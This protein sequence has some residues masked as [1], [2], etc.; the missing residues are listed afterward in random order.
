M[1]YQRNDIARVRIPRCRSLALAAC[2]IT[3]GSAA[4]AQGTKPEPAP[5][6]DT[7]DV[8]VTVQ[9]VVVTT[10]AECP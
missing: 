10:G 7:R 8:V 3:A 5:A 9:D 4:W 1:V 2:W 6:G